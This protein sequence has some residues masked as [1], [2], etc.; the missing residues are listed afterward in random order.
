MPYLWVRLTQQTMKRILFLLLFLGSLACYSS[1]RPKYIFYFI[2][3]GMGHNAL[4]LTEACLAEASGDSVGFS[5]LHFTQFPTVGFATT[6]CANRRTTDS[7]AAGTA[8]ATGQK[9]S[10]GTIGMNAARSEAL[11]SIAS[12]AREQGMRTGVATSVSIDHATPAAFYAHQPTRNLYYEIAQ[13]APTTG[14]DLYAGAG[15]V[16]PE[17]NGKP[18]VYESL[19]KAGYRLTRG[20]RAI[21]GRRAVLMQEEGCN[22][23][24]LPLA[25]DRQEGDLSLPAIT[26]RSIDFL[27]QNGGEHKGFFLMVEG[28]QIDWAAHSNDAAS[29]VEEVKD[30]DS[31]ICVALNFYH[32]HPDETLIVVTA[33]HETGGLGLGT[34]HLGYDTYYG[35][36]SAQRCSVGTLSTA[37]SQAADWSAA[38]ETLRD[39]LGFGTRVPITEAEWAE[40]AAVYASRP[41]KTADAAV[42]LL[43]RH[44][45]VG[46]TT[47][48]HTATY[49]PVFAIGAGA[50]HFAGRLDNTQIATRLQKLIVGE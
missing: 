4:A 9:S 3:D 5:A 28:G 33:D 48:A 49:V 23:S 35:L 36:L 12:T 20:D 40:L 17:E 37:L 26:R 18:S 11:T 45:G 24:N 22:P 46:W 6:W 27:Q 43:A 2:G 7:A 39:S 32:E 1:E 34:G 13:E 14:L 21:S 38:C 15:F 30:F 47:G 50:E 25:I 19:E 31:A 10:V 29:L 44:A 42:A 41:K 8:L 16:K